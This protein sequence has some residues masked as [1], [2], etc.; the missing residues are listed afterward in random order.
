MSSEPYNLQ[1]PGINENWDWHHRPSGG[2]GFGGGRGGQLQP[3]TVIDLGDAMRKNPHLKVF[4]ANGWFDL[5]TPF[6]GTEHDIAQMMLPPSLVG[7]VSFGYYP[8]GHMVYL[9]V[10]ALKEMHA[11]LEKWYPEAVAK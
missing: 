6:F 4:S 9:N 5:A 11:D 1:G 8:A 7:N 3:D 2:G 10:D